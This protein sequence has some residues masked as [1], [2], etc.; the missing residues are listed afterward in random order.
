MSTNLEST[1]YDGTGAASKKWW[2]SRYGAGDQLGAGN[3]L[4]SDRTLEGIRSV[5][6]GRVIELG[7]E[8]HPAVPAF[9]PRAWQ[10]LILAHGSLEE[11]WLDKGATDVSFFEESVWQSYQIGTHLD[12][13][14]HLGIAGRFYNGTPY[15]EFYD[16]HG[17]TKLGIEHV[18]PWVGRGVLL[19]VAGVLG[20]PIEEGFVITAEHLDAAEA[21]ADVTVGPG[22]AVLVNTGWGRLWESDPGRYAAGQPGIGWEGAHWL[23]ARRVSL[24]GADNSSF[25]PRPFERE[26]FSW[27]VHQ[28]LLAET[29]TFIL[30]NIDLAGLVTA[31]TS[32]FLFILSPIKTRGST[33]SMVAPLAVI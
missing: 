16:P 28:H 13:L 17:L 24:V 30:E 26:A 20:G 32:T 21:K 9:D 4:N 23:T 14:G 27:A 25:E 33:A 29:G 22:D 8:L 1:P 3:E 11:L 18:R 31:A 10:Q 7:R 2:P 6:Q 5:Q 12:A 19:D 15:T